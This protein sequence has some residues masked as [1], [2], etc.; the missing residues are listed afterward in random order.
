MVSLLRNR[1]FTTCLTT[2]RELHAVPGAALELWKVNPSQ[3][4]MA[5]A[6]GSSAPLS[7]FEPCAQDWQLKL[8]LRGRS[9]WTCL[10][11]TLVMQDPP[12]TK[13]TCVCDWFMKQN[14]LRHIAAT[15]ALKY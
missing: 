7:Y 4:V 2:P 14:V 12:S 10:V 8:E 13:L 15:Y 9:A 6:A 3:E 11:V 1:K 5:A